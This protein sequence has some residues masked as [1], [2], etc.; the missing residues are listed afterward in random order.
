MPLAHQR[1]ALLAHVQHTNSPYNLPAMGTKSAY[2]ANREGGAERFAAPAVQKS[3]AVD[4]ALITY[5]DALLRDGA[6]TIVTTAR[7]HDAHTLYLWQTV[8]GIG[9]I[10]RRVWLYAIHEVHRFPRGQDVVSSGRLGKGARESAGKRY[11]TSGTKIGHAHLQWAFA[12]AAVLCLRDHPAAQKDLVR[13]EPKHGTGKALTIRAQKLARAVY[14]MLTRQMAFEREMCFQRS[15]RGAEEPGASL[16]PQGM[17]LH[18][19]LAGAACPASANA[20]APRGHKTLRPAPLIGHALSLPFVA[21]LVAN[22]LRVLPLT[23]A[24]FSLDNATR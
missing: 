17:N 6:R 24:W 20:K 7:P 15:G 11:G 1:A 22:G 19:A 23:R 14:H 10:L 9:K 16:A 8:P 21:A 2:K 3:I 5:Y 18:E 4:L 12:E 13:L